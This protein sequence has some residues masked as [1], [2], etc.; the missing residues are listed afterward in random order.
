MS[1][2]SQWVEFNAPFEGRFNH[3]YLDIRGFVTT[4]VGN[5]IDPMSEAVK[6]PWLDRQG[7]LV[8]PNTVG[9]EW[10]RIKD[11][12]YLKDA[13]AK[14]AG[15]IATLHLS[16]SAIDDLVLQ[17]FDSDRVILSRRFKMNDLPL[18][19]QLAIHSMA[20]AMGAGFGYPAFT[21]AVNR[22]DWETAARESYIPDHTNAGLVPRNAKNRE[23]LLSC[24][25]QQPM[26]SVT[27]LPP[28][29][30]TPATSS[31]P[32]TNGRPSLITRLLQVLGLR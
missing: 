11:S 10:R 6:L 7:N 28:S 5:L 9:T 4:G 21:A 18:N 17:H 32:T 20:W 25:T 30:T 24:L 22:G 12:T 15:R 3:M 23:L 13:G 27:M 1:A 31:T 8:S 26:A 16:E 14:A 2:R 29:T 19:A